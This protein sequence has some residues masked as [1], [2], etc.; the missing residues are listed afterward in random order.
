MSPLDFIPVSEES[1][2]IVD[3]GPLC[4]NCARPDA[5]LAPVHR[6]YVVAAAWDAEI[7]GEIVGEA[8]EKVLD[9]VE[10]WCFSC[11]SLYPHRALG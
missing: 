10:T 2:R 4:E 11:R 1:S 7:I 8:S 5:D 3:E 6:M 9:D